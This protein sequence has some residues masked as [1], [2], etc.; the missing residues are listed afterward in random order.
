MH[1][2]SHVHAHAC[3]IMAS[4]RSMCT[5]SLFDYGIAHMV[6]EPKHSG[7]ST[8]TETGVWKKGTL[9]F[10]ALLEAWIVLF[11]QLEYLNQGTIHNKQN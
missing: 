10:N 3:T 5:C 7:S 2:A 8:V 11:T 4:M 9:C 6:G 1:H